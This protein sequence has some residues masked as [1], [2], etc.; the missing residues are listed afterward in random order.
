VA[1]KITKRVVEGMQPQSRNAIFWDGEIKGFGV[2]CTPRGVKSY[3]FQYSVGSG[4]GAPKRRYSIGRHGSPW[5]PETARSEAKR[6]AGAVEAGADPQAEREAGRTAETVSELC[7][8]YLAEGVSHKK[9]STLQAD[10]G[11]IVH[12]IKP[13][14]GHKRVKEVTRADVERLLVDVMAGKTV[15][16]E[17]KGKERGRGSLVRG[18]AG[19]AAQCVTLLGTLLA[20]AVNRGMRTDNPAHGVKKPPVRKMERFLS[21]QEIARLA[22]ALTAEAETS[23][24]PY[25]TAM[26]RLLM[27]TGCRRGEIANLRWDQVS[28]D[29]GCLFL[30]D[31]KTGRKTVYLNA[32]ALAVLEGLTKL[33][34]NPYVIAGECE[35]RPYAGIDTVWYRV[36]KA[37]ELSE[38]RLHDLRHSFA[39]IGAAG[40]LGLPMIGALLGHKT[41]TTTQRYAHLSA[42]PLRAAN[43]AIG[44]KIAEA[45]ALPRATG[46]GEI[47]M[48]PVGKGGQ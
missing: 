5:T 4:R 25:P 31:S 23:N 24:F 12:H 35:G 46:S 38:V 19:V 8:T 7:D 18:G 39:S 15:P 26:I 27:L 1:D 21:A 20:F 45:M 41:T 16:P 6:L 14:I 43:E 47:V 3:F 44:A 29:H 22:A 34:G 37:A 40:G 11:R 13:L 9:P 36:R 32:P 30:P 10:R 2:V 48:T 33:D 17:R 42:D 28:V